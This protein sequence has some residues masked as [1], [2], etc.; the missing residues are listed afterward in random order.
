[1]SET[2]YSVDDVKKMLGIT[3]RTLRYY[4]EIGLISPSRRTAGG[5]RIYDEHVLRQLKHILRIK[6]NLGLS[7]DGIHR[8]L[9]MEASLEELESTYK[10]TGLTDEK[11]EILDEATE[12][13]Q[14]IIN[15]TQ[16]KIEKLRVIEQ[17]FLN[18]LKKAEQMKEQLL[19]EPIHE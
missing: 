2:F 6:E 8:V 7:L 17:S 13:L 11:L 4:E 12:L 16:E 19:Q 9:V 14:E 15:G 18:R 5:H 10:K 3:A 1:M